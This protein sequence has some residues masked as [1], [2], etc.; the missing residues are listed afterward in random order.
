MKKLLLIFLLFFS[1]HAW[2]AH[3]GHPPGAATFEWIKPDP[4]FTGPVRP[5][6]IIDEYRLYCTVGVS[7]FIVI[8][9]GYDTEIYEATGLVSGLHTCFFRSYSAAQD[10]ESIDSNVVTFTIFGVERPNA[11]S[12]VVN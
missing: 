4:A 10:Q 3:P 9:P 8:I 7:N 1:G 5:G 2:T 11:P 12:L 6:T